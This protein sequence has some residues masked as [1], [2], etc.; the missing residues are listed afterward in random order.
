M[1]THQI[2]IAHPISP[3]QVNA[4]KAFMKA[5]KIEFETTHEDDYNPEFVSKI[6]KSKKQYKD[7][8]YISVQQKDIKKL[9][10]L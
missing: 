9:L 1:K 4:L 8:E 3:E 5:L 2:F 6:L 7:G 10:G